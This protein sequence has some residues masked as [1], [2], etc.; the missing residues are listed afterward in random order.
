MTRIH[1]W[2]LRAA[3]AALLVVAMG[4]GPRGLPPAGLGSEIPVKPGAETLFSDLS[5]KCFFVASGA[6][7][8]ELGYRR[9]EGRFGWNVPD[10]VCVFDARGGAVESSDPGNVARVKF[11]G[12]RV[13]VT[14][15]M[16]VEGD[17]WR[18]VVDPDGAGPVDGG[19]VNTC[20][21]EGSAQVYPDG[22]PPK[23][24]IRRK[25]PDD[26]RLDA[27]YLQEFEIARDLAPGVHVLRIENAWSRDHDPAGAS[28]S[29]LYSMRVE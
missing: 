19:W 29:H 23:R 2:R 20:T 26:P 28:F 14:V 1:R 18:F 5:L 10:D 21:D 9:G 25:D 6:S 22:R 7:L 3:A 11:E 24:R 15:G 17:E 13:A 27:R 12:T 8:E 16:D 4:C